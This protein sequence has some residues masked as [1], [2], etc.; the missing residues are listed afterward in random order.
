MSSRARLIT[1]VLAAAA[2]AVA[3]AVLKPGDDEQQATTTTQATTTK[4]T[5]TT[6]PATT[7]TPSATAP[8]GPV[9]RV[10]G[11]QPVGGV[12]DIT[13]KQGDTIRLTV[14]SDEP[15][16]VHMHGYDVA[17]EAAPGAPA[18][19]VVPATINGVFEVE[20]EKTAVQ[21]AKLTVEP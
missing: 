3:F 18:R 5:A 8:A 20:L 15:Q 16:E 11:G 1:L 9:I 17:K 6:P 4:T 2:A 14:T 21:I 7:T 13:V 12:K 10:K 19:F